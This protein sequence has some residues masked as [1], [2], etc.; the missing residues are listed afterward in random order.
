[1]HRIRIYLKVLQKCK[2]QHSRCTSRIPPVPL[3]FRK[4][5]HLHRRKGITERCRHGNA[6]SRLFLCSFCRSQCLMPAPSSRQCPYGRYQESFNPVLFR[7]EKIRFRIITD[8]QH[9]S[10]FTGVFLHFFIQTVSFIRTLIT[11]NKDSLIPGNALRRQNLLQLL[12]IQI[13]IRG[14]YNL[15]AGRTDFLKQINDRFSSGQ[16][17]FLA[18]QFAL[19]HSL[20]FRFRD[21]GSFTYMS[22]YFIKICTVQLPLVFPA[23]RNI[24]IRCSLR[25]CSPFNQCKHIFGGRHIPDEQCIE[26]IKGHHIRFLSYLQYILP[27]QLCFRLSR[28]CIKHICLRQHIIQNPLSCH[29]HTVCINSVKARNNTV[30]AGANPDMQYSARILFSYGSEAE[31]LSCPHKQHIMR[32]LIRFNDTGQPQGFFHHFIRAGRSIHKHCLFSL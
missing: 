14:Q 2:N 10:L 13:H 29:D 17:V 12:F 23:Q 3:R 5:L 31:V 19:L 8:M 28:I 24:V 20:S 18:C 21:T 6:Q 9:R 15:L 7:T 11:R 22:V 25:I 1:M 26:Y 32:I 16:K 27:V 4:I 30:I